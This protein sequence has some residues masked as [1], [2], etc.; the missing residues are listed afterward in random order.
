M[1]GTFA[2]SAGYYDAYYKKAQQIRRLIKNDFLSAFEK[3]DVI[4]GPTT[5]GPAF[6]I[7]EKSDDQV[8]MYLQDIFTIS[9]NLAG[10]PAMSFPAGFIGKLPVGMQLTGRYFD[11][12][13]LLNIAHQFQQDTR[14]HKQQPG[15]LL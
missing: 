12:A 11:E 2:L 8:A 4:L 13:R 15:D 3:V 5:P 14:W 1:V 10:L 7:G 9:A 6:A